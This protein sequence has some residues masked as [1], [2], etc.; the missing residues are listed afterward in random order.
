MSTQR[1]SGHTDAH[2]PSAA[3]ISDGAALE[4]L[5]QHS[6]NALVQRALERR[7]LSGELAP[8]TKLIETDIATAL[9]VSR[10]PVREAFRTLAQ[11][12][13][14]HTE[15]N[16]G[17]FVREIAPEE[18]DDLY[19]LRAVL[20]GLIGRLAAARIG[21]PQLARL[22]AL[23]KQMQTVGRALDAAA[24]FPLNIEFHDL[25]AECTGNRALLANYRRVV[26]EL[27]LYR[28]Q[29]VMR[30]SDNI[31]LSTREHEAVVEAVAAGDSATAERLLVGHVIS[32]RE[33]LHQALK[34]PPGPGGAAKRRA[35]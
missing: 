17:V 22:R 35:A 29:I 7:I 24:Y 5:Q 1:P 8:G 30:N 21:R 23:V 32:S 2:I 3:E 12:G 9:G 26:N 13:L 33:R 34:L 6:L 18:V 15:K 28:R 11:S 25:L 14:V 10:G 20:D 4:V 31:T 16:R 19:E 27:T